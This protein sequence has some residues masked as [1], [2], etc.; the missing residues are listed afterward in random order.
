MNACWY[1]LSKECVRYAA[2]V[3]MTQITS[4]P[5]P[6]QIDFSHKNGRTIFP[7]TIPYSTSIHAPHELITSPV[8]TARL[9][10]KFST[11][12]DTPARLTVSCLFTLHVIIRVHS[13]FNTMLAR[14]YG[15]LGRIQHIGSRHLYHR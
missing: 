1:C 2:Q 10:L 8:K 13:S 4:P 12:M 7:L 5:P 11:A 3:V 6:H 9:R 14:T 15:L